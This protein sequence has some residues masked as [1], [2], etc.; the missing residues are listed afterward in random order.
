[1]G[2]RKEGDLVWYMS[3]HGQRLHGQYVR[4]IEGWYEL[5]FADGSTAICRPSSVSPREPDPRLAARR[6][7]GGRDE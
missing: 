6:Q 3:P 7:P 5:R 1:M 4:D 2:E